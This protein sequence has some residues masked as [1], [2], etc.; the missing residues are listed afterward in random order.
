MYEPA[1]AHNLGLAFLWPAFAAASVSELAAA[2]A[3]NFADL[4]IGVSGPEAS[5]PEWATPHT[6]ALALESVRLLDFTTGSGRFPALLVTPFALHGGAIGDLAP[7]HSLVTALRAAGL[8]RLFATDWRPATPAMRY[9]GIDDYLADLNVLVDAIGAPVDLIGMCQ[10]GFLAL[11]YAARFP[12]KVRKLVLAAAPVDV[13]AGA[14][15]LSAAAE[16]TPLPIFREV[17]RL[18]DGLVPGRR[19]LKLWA[20]YAVQSEDIRQ[21]LQTDAPAGSPAAAKLEG[22]FRD[23]YAWTLDLPGR[24]FVETVERLYKR[25]ELARGDFVALGQKLDLALMRTPLYLLAARDDELVAPA[26]L[27]AAARLVGTPAADL[28]TAQAPCRHL[29]LFM[30]RQILQEVWP[31][32]VRWLQ[33]PAALH[34]TAPRAVLHEAVAH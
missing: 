28:C 23:W 31:P 32:V 10:G 21:L 27:L 12:E 15:A 7:G 4:A 22:R 33:Q 11:V 19:V 26:Q 2:A 8:S 25:N 34:Q 9:R 13:A 3:R 17:V 5:E 20:P 1:G 6:L 14:S 18:G 29:G 16:S 30:G 24:F